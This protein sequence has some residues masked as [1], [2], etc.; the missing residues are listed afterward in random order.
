M[1]EKRLLYFTAGGVSAF[2]WKGGRLEAEETFAQREEGVAA[3]AQYLTR[4]PT[5]LYYLLA[6]VVEED[7]ATD[8]IPAV[9][10]SDRREL[11]ARKLS[12]RYRDTSLALTLSLG[13]R[14]VGDRREEHMLFSSFT[15]T[16]QF[17]PWL[18]ALGTH[19][20]RLVG[21]YSPPLLAPLVG[22]RLGYKQE[23]Y[24]LVTVEKAGLRQ[25]FVHQGAVRFS[26]LGRITENDA[27]KTAA[28]CAAE[29]A[30]IQ[31][32]LVSLRI[33]SRDGPRL[34]AVVLAPAAD[35][36]AYTDI[37][38]S[39]A[40]IDYEVLKEEDAAQR[41]GLK[42]APAESTA[43][44]LFLHVLAGTQV[45]AQFASDTLRRQYHLWR[46]RLALLTVGAAVFAFCLLLS[47][48]KMLDMYGVNESAGADR[49]LEAAAQQQY[50]RIQA[51]FPKTPT[52]TDRLDA[53]VKNYGALRAQ[54]RGPEGLLLQ[55][56][57]ALANLPQIEID[58]IDW[59]A[60]KAPA[61]AQTAASQSNAAKAGEAAP[62][63]AAANAN[64]NAKPEDIRQYAT[65]QG[66]VVST[67]ASDFRTVTQL[68]DQFAGALRGQPGIQLVSRRLPFDISAG[69]SLSGDI[70]AARETEVPRFT[71]V[72]SKP[73]A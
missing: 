57:R 30:R 68:V 8:S 43:E 64:A 27:T 7:F 22:A 17:Q 20:A 73:G 40:Q 11:L 18:T 47:G 70:G 63:A 46:A 51:T 36:Q 3:F 25:T 42:S 66:H 69:Q 6:D 9:R 72:I 48:F 38:V 15:N 60:S 71:I 45:G 2:R 19:E 16:Q 1:A 41:C 12:Q 14:S 21:L 4:R 54:T 58:S 49:R 33:L 39:N 24:L 55:I 13:T 62:A 28:A 26:R 29:S 23:H 61:A 37:C 52:S 32:Y 35:W 5:A 10:G 31:Q 44:A 56:S 50:A 65:I 67:Q 59:D 34:K 53:I